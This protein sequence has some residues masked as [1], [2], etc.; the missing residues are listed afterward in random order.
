M[1][2]LGFEGEGPEVTL[3]SL[4]FPG[5]E[6]PVAQASAILDPA[7]KRSELFHPFAVGDAETAE[8]WATCPRRHTEMAGFLVHSSL[9]HT[10]PEFLTSVSA[11][12]LE[13]SAHS[14]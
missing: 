6:S 8:G 2:V 9:H 10:I 1:A 3:Q 12:V 5:R 11:S 7:W 4:G 14:L 13:A